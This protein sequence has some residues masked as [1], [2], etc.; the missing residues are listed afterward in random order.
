ML[1]NYVNIYDIII[2]NKSSNGVPAISA[3]FLSH[4]TI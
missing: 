2:S 3:I 1:T 4:F